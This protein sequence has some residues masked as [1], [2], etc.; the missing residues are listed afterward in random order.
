MDSC[1]FKLL[2]LFVEN[3]SMTMQEITVYTDISNRTVSKRIKELNDILGDTAH[4]SEGIERYQLTINDYS[5]FL[6]LETQFLKGELD[7]NDPV[8]REAF[9]I[10]ILIK[11][12]DYVSIDEIADELTVSRKVINKNLKQVKEDII[13]YNGKIVSKTGKGIKVEFQSDFD[14]INALKNFVVNHASKPQWLDSISE[15][16]E[17]IKEMKVTKQTYHQIVNNIIT[18]KLFKDYGYSLNELPQNYSQ[19]W[20]PTAFIEEIEDMLEEQF[21]SITKFELR[22]IFSPLDLYKNQYLD[23]KKVDDIFQKNYKSLFEPFK[24]EFLQYGLNPKTVYERI[25]WHMLFSINRT[26][27]Y[28]RISE[29]LPQNISDNYPI[30]LE[31]SLKLANKIEAEYDVHLPKNEIN[32]YV[33]Y[34]EMFLEEVHQGSSDQVKVAFVGSIRSSVREFIENKLMSVF[35]K[36]RAYTFTNIT[37]FENSN[38]NFLLVFADKP[39]RVKNNQVIDVGTAFRPEALS[40]IMQVSVIEQLIKQKKIILSVAHLEAN[41]Y[42]DAVDK[43]IDNQIQIGQLTPKFKDTLAAREKKTNNIFSNGIA[44][45]HAVDDSS[46]QRIL[47]SV[48]IIDNKISFRKNNLKLIFLIGI[49]NKLNQDLIDATSRLYDFIGLISRNEILHDNFIEYDNSKQLIQIVEGV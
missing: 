9:I 5:R 14:R 32:Y 34:F 13:K 41:D 26:L 38:D 11:N 36:L 42:Y 25:K 45:P 31:L 37:D 15:I 49:P 30:S 40:I 1:L 22:F 2:K 10:D 12:H 24:D 35:D 6:D 46:N 39:F 21:E 17:A 27:L 28:T 43:M 4:I 7:L 23:A 44:I 48:G 19:L 47:V 33:I 20:K 3:G 8:K 18:L 16:S 29:V